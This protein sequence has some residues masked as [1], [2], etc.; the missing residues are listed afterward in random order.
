MT[1]GCDGAFFNDDLLLLF[2]DGTSDDSYK[3]LFMADGSNNMVVGGSCAGCVIKPMGRGWKG[4]VT[5]RLFILSERFRGGMKCPKP[6][7]PPPILPTVGGV[8]RKK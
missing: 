3:R 5:L 8:E 7:T 2:L 4:G 6:P 1:G